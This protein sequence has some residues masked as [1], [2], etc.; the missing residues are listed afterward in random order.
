MKK[1]LLIAQIVVSLLLII[2]IL[3]QPRG[4]ALGAAFG[5]AGGFYGTLRG[6][7]KKIFWGTV[8]LAVLFIVLALL[9][10]II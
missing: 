4:T 7:Q 6:A 9:N 2:S 3:L 10:L 8:S 5:Q 1:I